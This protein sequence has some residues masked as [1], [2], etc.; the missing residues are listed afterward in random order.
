MASKIEDEVLEATGI[1]PKKGED[2]ADFLSRL[3]DYLDDN[4]KFTDKDYSALSDPA[5]KWVNSACTAL[6]KKQDIPEFPAAEGNEGRAKSSKKEVEAESG[7][8]E[9]EEVVTK[10]TKKAP[11]KAAAKDEKKAVAKPTDIKKVAKDEPKEDEKKAAPAKKEKVEKPAKAAAVKEPKE[12]KK[13]GGK[14]ADLKK[15]ILAKPARTNAELMELM[16]KKGHEI[17]MSTLSTIRSGFLHSM[18]VIEDE[19]RLAPKS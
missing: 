4:K 10:E 11:A 9:T 5:Q 2:R 1:S 8:D 19:G 16:T 12:K 13:A 14:S 15:L 17:T 7:E 18:Q 3:T 6:G